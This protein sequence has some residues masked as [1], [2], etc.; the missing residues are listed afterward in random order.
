MKLS[1]VLMEF[2]QLCCSEEVHRLKW[3]SIIANRMLAVL[4]NALT[5]ENAIRKAL[6]ESLTTTF[7]YLAQ[8]ISNL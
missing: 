8:M 1:G 7:L 4:K 3:Y 2:A 5:T 6:K